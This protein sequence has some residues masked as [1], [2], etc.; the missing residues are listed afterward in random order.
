MQVESTIEHSSLLP[1]P[2]HRWLLHIDLEDVKH[3]MLTA[4]LF[5]LSRSASWPCSMAT[6]F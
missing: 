4:S 1:M 6:S 3:L 5:F 2:V